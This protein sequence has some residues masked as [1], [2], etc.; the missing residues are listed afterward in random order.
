[1]AETGFAAFSKT[2]DKT[3]QI[4]K[5][6]EDAYGWPQERRNQSYQAL[7][8]VLHAL[9]D[10]LTIEE[11]PQFGAQLPMLVKGIYYEGWDPTKTPMKMT[12]EELLNRIRR[13]FPY[14]IVGGIE[15]LVVTVLDA[16]RGYISPGEWADLRAILPADVRRLLPAT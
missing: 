4:L 5:Q 9:R 13:E 14:D 8:T 15:R 11:I 10:R 2:V 16:L 1:M 3:N 7:R 6:I 12:G